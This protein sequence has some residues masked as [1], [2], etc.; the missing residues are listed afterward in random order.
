MEHDSR[1]R[2]A[3][4]A[5]GGVIG[6]AGV[7]AAAASSHL[8]DSRNLAAVATIGL[9]HGP[10]L[11]A[12]ALA[13][14]G[15]ILAI[16]GVLLAVGTLLFAGDLAAREWLGHGLFAGAAPMGGVAMI[17]GWLAV[18]IAAAAWTRPGQI[19]K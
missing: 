8:G 2:K 18:I 4:L 12:L 5:A 17:C 16:A 3:L 15:R 10:V 11:L 9:A 13:G 1:T 7:M 19:E 14:R 6:M